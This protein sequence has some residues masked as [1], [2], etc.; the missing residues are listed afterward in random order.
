MALN[1]KPQ[2]S[3]LLIVSNRLPITVK[4]EE[5]GLA[6]SES[7]GG[8]A[9]G[10]RAYL[11]GIGPAQAD[12]GY[13]WIGWP[14]SDIPEAKKTTV[15]ETLC[16]E[17]DALPVFL[18]PNDITRFYDGF[19]NGTLWPLFH[20]FY[21]YASFCQEDWESY[22]RI[23]EEFCK[24]LLR[25]YRPGDTIWIND[26]HLMLLPGM[27]RNHLPDAQIG[28]F[29]HIP[30]PSYETFRLM[31]R[32]WSRAILEGILGS[33]LVGFHTHDYCQYFLHSTQR[34][35]GFEHNLGCVPYC[36]RVVKVDTFPMGIEME[37]FQTA[38]SNPPTGEEWDNLKLSLH[39]MKT[40]IS[41][42]RLDY[43]KGILNRLEAYD[44]FLEQ[45]P[46]WRGHVVHVS[47]VVPSRERVVAYDDM[48]QRINQAVGSI[49]GRYGRVG[50]TP[51]HYHYRQLDFQALVAL[52]AAGDVALVTPLRD[53]MNLVA[54]E[55]VA[56]CMDG[57]G[58]LVLSE[59]AG[60]ASELGEAVLVNPNNRQEMA[61]AIWSSLEM[62]N[63]EQ[64]QRIRSM[65]ER[66]MNYDVVHWAEDFLS[67]LGQA[68]QQQQ[69]RRHILVQGDLRKQLM[70]E[71]A[72]AKCPLILTDYD[73]TLVNFFRDPEKAAPSERV[74]A[75]LSGLSRREGAKVV[76][77]SGRLQETLNRWV[78]HLEIGLAAE[79]G[80]YVRESGVAEWRQL[81]VVGVEWKESIR[82][83]LRMAA[84]RLPGAFV[85]EKH[86]SLGWHYRAANPEL[87][88]LRARELVDV[89]TQFTANC[90]V[91]VLQGNK[92]IEVRSGQVNKGVAGLHFIAKYKPDFIL[93]VGDDWTDED[94]FKAMPTDA[95]TVKVGSGRSHARFALRNPG[96]VI[97]LLEALS[98]TSQPKSAIGIFSEIPLEDQTVGY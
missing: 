60:A 65:Q 41:V 2:I 51:V 71:F 29:L 73:G 90:D 87:G 8:L 11:D 59:F 89:L 23:N 62:P 14:G 33:D 45:H 77:V 15:S 49:N 46:D 55:Y 9:I 81:G 70:G 32:T 80:A 30:F 16:G 43:T 36:E 64:N 39:G 6:F 86:L 98:H 79:H 22:V 31:P 76:L 10:M 4:C 94:L 52:Y 83:L 97:A 18:N 91:Q 20:S 75:L 72:K 74:L 19:C 28:W 17:Y 61:D 34:M 57:R 95:F 5:S 7:M 67:T 82:P 88:Q 96:E 93:A 35:L 54:K 78:G 42:D 37:R 25:I 13:L 27:L 84:D 58:V 66:L 68:W 1:V 26:Y 21:T 12:Q 69:A 3:R 48:K 56:C 40:I 44:L 53:G 92:V 47:I 24:V 85:E 63:S 50:W 38:F